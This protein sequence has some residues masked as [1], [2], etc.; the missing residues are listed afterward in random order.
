MALVQNIQLLTEDKGDKTN[1]VYTEVY[2][3]VSNPP[4]HLP[5]VNELQKLFEERLKLQESAMVNNSRMQSMFA[6][7]TGY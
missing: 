5:R 7:V 3:P 4:G 6:R 2:V 1:F